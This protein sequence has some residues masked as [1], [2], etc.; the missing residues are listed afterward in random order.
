MPEETTCEE[1]GR[2]CAELIDSRKRKTMRPTKLMDL[3]NDYV[4]TLG[5]LLDLRA[6]ASSIIES[7]QDICL[8]AMD[9]DTELIRPEVQTIVS[10]GWDRAWETQYEERGLQNFMAYLDS[11]W[12]ERKAHWKWGKPTATSFCATIVQSSCAGKSRLVYSYV[13]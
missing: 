6:L 12:L 3:C 5:P 11:L 1:F 8:N 2:M 7:H 13:T 10:D 4:R 9:V